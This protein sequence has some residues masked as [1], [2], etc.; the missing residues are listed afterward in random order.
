ME[1][2]SGPHESPPQVPP[3]NG[4]L[5]LAN[6]KESRKR[7]RQACTACNAKRV[8]CNVTEGFPCRN[9]AERDL[10]CEVRESRRGKHPRPQKSGGGIDN[11]RRRP[12]NASQ[13]PDRMGKEVAVSE[14]PAA[15]PAPFTRD[16]G[17]MDGTS[18]IGNA[19]HGLGDPEHTLKS[20]RDR[21]RSD[22][23]HSDEERSVFLGESNSIRYVNNPTPYDPSQ[24]PQG[25]RLLHRVTMIPS[26]AADLIP[27]FEAER[28]QARVSWLQSQG[29]FAFPQPSHT[30]TL[31]QIYFQWFHP[32]F[33]VVNEP[34]VWHELHHG[35]ISPLLLNAMLFVAV[36]HC[37]ED[38]L[39]AIGLEAQKAK[40][41][42]YNRAKDLYDADY[43]RHKLV[44]VQSLFVL[45]FWRAG[46]LLEKDARFWLAAAISLA[47]T[48][49]FHRSQG[50]SNAKEGLKKR[51][52]WA[53]YVRER[54]CAAALGLPNRIRDEDLDVEP[55]T[56]YDFERSF[57][58]NLPEHIRLQSI[59]YQIGMAD[60][61]RFLGQIVHSGYLPGK[62]LSPSHRDTLRDQL[63][64]WKQALPDNM[65]LGQDF[66]RPSS[67]HV[68]MLH[69]AYNNLLVLLYRSDYLDCDTQLAESGKAL[70]AASQIAR[71]IEDLLPE[72]NLRHAQIHV[73]TNLFN[74]LCIHT[75]HLRRAEG[76]GVA[77][78][79]HR[80]K[81]C[82]LGLE[83]LQKTWEMQNWILQLF[84][85]YLDRSTAARLLAQTDATGLDEHTRSRVASGE[86]PER[87][88]AQ[89]SLGHAGAQNMPDTPW[90]WSA[91]QQN[92]FLFARIEDTFA[93]GEGTM[94]EWG[95]DSMG[96]LMPPFEEQQAQGNWQWHPDH[97]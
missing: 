94:N 37:D 78:A 14:I 24:T 89:M 95:S 26:K 71:I 79:E 28:R 67:F 83:E 16:A 32:Y 92:D 44:V 29:A 69:L 9:C 18:T 23:I 96:S 15:A 80:A 38:I 43:E 10:H 3:G 31:L 62:Q 20:P 56:F 60:L 65:Q 7:A 40:W 42:F 63:A 13:K 39:H 8:K 33:A 5:F 47:Q 36:I 12:S 34:D 4:Y 55:L 66:E 64:S 81:M 53:I 19:T 45:S 17:H 51:I 52:W 22:D 90:S 77:I 61:S 57:D 11:S 25:S 76:T 88:F 74:A 73:I 50:D 82:L 27:E 54:Q 1:P 2:C 93:F 72:G 6:M 84:F 97:G 85:Q 68:S 30:A 48:K 70:Q 58:G 91:E 75:T 87:D 46:P 86:S 35:T 21:N 41:T 49:A 59:S